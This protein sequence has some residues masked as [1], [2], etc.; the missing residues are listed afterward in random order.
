MTAFH[1]QEVGSIPRSNTQH[2]TP[3]NNYYYVVI[4]NNEFVFGVVEVE[5]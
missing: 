3:V 5:A 2:N 4:P 1:V